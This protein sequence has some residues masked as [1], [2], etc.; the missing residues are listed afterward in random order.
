MQGA[1]VFVA[2][3]M[4]TAASVGLWVFTGGLMTLSGFNGTIWPDSDLKVRHRP[5]TS[6]VEIRRSRWTIRILNFV[7]FLVG[8]SITWLFWRV[9]VAPIW[10]SSFIQPR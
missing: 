4:F 1:V 10:T 9:I 2:R 6:V 3:L 5:G 8:L 7:M